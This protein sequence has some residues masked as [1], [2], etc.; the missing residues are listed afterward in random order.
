MVYLYA[1]FNT[2]ELSEDANMKAGIVDDDLIFA[3]AFAKLLR[4]RFSGFFRTQDIFLSP[5]SFLSKN[6]NYDILFLDIEMPGTTGIELARNQIC[7][8]T[9]IIFVTNR[10]DLV[11]EAYNT[12]GSVGFVRKSAIEKDLKPIL[13]RIARDKQK[14]L[15]IPVKTGDIITKVRYSD[16]IY[17][18]KIAHN[19]IIKTTDNTYSKRTTISEMESILV[20]H[21]FVRTHIGFLVNLSHIEFIK[22][23]RTILTGGKTAPI[24][25]QNLKL[26]RDKFLERNVALHE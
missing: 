19:V 11:F 7:A 5:Q 16:I 26:V 8:N 4:E 3:K 1:D 25:R 10:D 12:T 21:G 6:E 24:S 22:S 14:A 2:K 15:F 23:G 13:R 9:K 20:P 18:E 17:I